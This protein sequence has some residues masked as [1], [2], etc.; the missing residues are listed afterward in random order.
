[1][2]YLLAKK[3]HSTLEK[4]PYKACVTKLCR[5]Y[6]VRPKTAKKII[7]EITVQKRSKGAGRKI[8]DPD[9][10]SKLVQIGKELQRAGRPMARPEIRI[11]GGFYKKELKGDMSIFTE[12]RLPREIK[13]SKGWLDKFI[14]RN[15]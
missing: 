6:E 10:E 8:A 11:L 15:G 7:H 9:I 13:L 14:K 3:L 2:L 1:M 12:G 4:K 5:L